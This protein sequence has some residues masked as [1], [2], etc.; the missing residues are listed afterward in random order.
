MCYIKD[1]VSDGN[2]AEEELVLG[3][4]DLKDETEAS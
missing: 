1:E 3:W 4:G 2:E